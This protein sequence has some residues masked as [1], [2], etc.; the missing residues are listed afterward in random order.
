MCISPSLTLLANGFPS[1]PCRLSWAA[2]QWEHPMYPGH[3]HRVVL[4]SHQA[5]LPLCLILLLVVPKVSNIEDDPY[6]KGTPILISTAHRA[7]SKLIPIVHCSVGT[8]GSRIYLCS[9]AS[10][11][12][13]ISVNTL[14]VCS[15]PSGIS[16]SSRIILRTLWRR[17]TPNGRL[18]F[19]AKVANRYS[20]HVVWVL[21]NSICGFVLRGTDAGCSGGEDKNASYY[22]KSVSMRYTRYARSSRGQWRDFERP[23]GLSFMIHVPGLH[24]S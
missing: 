20:G 14:L 19:S 8:T 10:I 15:S 9:W 21:S 13:I 24:P 1:L 16:T 17:T 7:P 12:T 18:R 3:H 22:N 5:L 2:L 6:S 11:T 4:K 23:S